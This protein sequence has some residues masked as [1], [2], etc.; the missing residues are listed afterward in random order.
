MQY[1]MIL[2]KAL[3]YGAFFYA[4]PSK[5]QQMTPEQ[6]VQQNL[7]SYNK[8]DIEGF[9]QSFGTDIALFSFGNPTPNTVGLTAVRQRYQN[10]FDQSPKLHST[11]VKRMVLGNKVIDHEHIVG[12]MGADTPVEMI[13]I[14]EVENE[15]IVRVTVIKD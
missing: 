9:M 13:L 15:K 4:T 11:I 2:Y 5:A 3:L 8:R 10:L 14:Y 6:I 1:K 12:R 7:D